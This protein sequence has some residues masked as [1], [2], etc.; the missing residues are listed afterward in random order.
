MK[1]LLE[2]MNKALEVLNNTRITDFGK[3]HDEVKKIITPFLPENFNYLVWEIVY[4]QVNKYKADVIFNLHFDFIDDK[5][6][7]TT[8]RKGKLVRCWFTQSIVGDTVEQLLINI[9][10]NEVNNKIKYHNEY[11]IHLKKEL[12]ENYIAVEKLLKIKESW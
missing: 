7:K 5:R 8:D 3:F 1:E 6:V 2:K 4:K 10:K 11:I 9:S 12:N